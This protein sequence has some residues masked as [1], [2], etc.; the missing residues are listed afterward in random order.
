MFQQSTAKA[1]RL[2]PDDNVGVAT[3]DLDAEATIQVSDA[4]VELSEPIAMGHKFALAPIASGD[5]VTKYG[6]TIGFATQ[7]IDPGN[8]VHSHNLAA[9]ALSHDYRIASEVPPPPDPILGRTFEGYRRADGKVGTRNYLAVIST[10]NCS[11]SVSKYIAGRFDRDLLKQYPHVDG[12]LALTHKGGCGLQYD[13]EDHHQLNRV[14]AGFAKHGN[15]AGYLLIGLGCEVGTLGHL[16]ED[17]QL[18][19]IG[20]SNPTARPLTLSIQDCGGT[21]NTVDEG[22]RILAEMLPGANALRRETVPASELVLGTEC[23]G[24]DG[25]SGVTANP[26]LGVASDLIVAA[27]GTAIL[28]ETPEIYGAEHLLVR[29]AK[30]REVGEALLERIAWWEA[31]TARFGA[32]IDNNP[33]PGNKAGGLTTIYEKSLGAVAKGGSTALAGVFR[34]AQP[35]R[36][37]GFVVMDSPG[38]DPASVTGM[39][40]SGA[41]V[42][43]FT[44][45][46]GSCFG[47]RPVPSVKIATNTPMYERMQGDMDVNAG[48]VLEG[49]SVRQ[50]GE[51]IFELILEVASGRQ[52]KSEAHGV[53][54]EEF[55]PWSIGPTL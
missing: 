9:D 49:T 22:I 25:N 37:K 20:Q 40:A 16:I 29:R 50:L 27:G 23:G 6:Q 47:C 54:E 11:A 1:L 3:C 44:T 7:S 53:G 24:S 2:H 42:I 46:R 17:Q 30:T 35:I 4:T 18:V 15:V 32:K 38:Y 55:L 52:T 39:V 13:S 21:Q 34:Y 31:F 10:V 51:Q 41:N 8:W 28:A 5:R 26:A 36:Q 43:C 48:V 12:I 14:L 33:T 45:G 19:Q